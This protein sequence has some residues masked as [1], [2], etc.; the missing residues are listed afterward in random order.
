MPGP[1]RPSRLRSTSRSGQIGGQGL[2]Q[3]A[4]NTLNTCPEQMNRCPYL[5]LVK[6]CFI[7]PRPRAAGDVPLRVAGCVAHRGH[8]VPRE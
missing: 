2:R 8:A 6:S 4:T 3:I 7:N 5:M 1:S